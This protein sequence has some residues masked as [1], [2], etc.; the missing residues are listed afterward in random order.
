MFVFFIV[1]YC[2]AAVMAKSKTGSFWLT[3]QINL[4]IQDTAVQGVIDLGAYVDV[5]DQQALA[6]EEVDYVFQAYDTANDDYSYSIAGAV[7]AGNIITFGVQLT[8]LNRGLNIVSADDRSLVSSGLLAFSDD[9]NSFFNAGDLY[10]DTFGPVAADGTRL[11]VN[12]SLY[13]TGIYHNSPLLA[14]REIRV[15]VRIKAKIVKVSRADWMSIAIQST[16]ADN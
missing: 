8:D 7:G 3:E 9:N 14:N 15:T 10:P 6:I 2:I 13:F 1:R 12:D 4:D 16:A 5:G 11:V